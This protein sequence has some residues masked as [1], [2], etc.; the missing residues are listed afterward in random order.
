MGHLIE[1]FGREFDR[2]YQDWR[3]I[4]QQLDPETIYRP[5]ASSGGS[6]GEQVVRSARVVEQTFGGITAN[7]WD[8]PFEWTLPETLTTAEKLLGYFDEVQATRARGFDLFKSD[9]DLMKEIMTP[10]GKMRLASLLL[11]TLVRA[12]H[13][14]LSACE[15][16][17]QIR[18]GEGINES[19][20]EA[21]VSQ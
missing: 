3:E 5:T 10:S 2:M 7:L 4:V 14:Q 11:D 6:C 15:I 18:S 13:Y 17:R 20:L 8:D 12:G 1:W 16:L 9:E 21:G 19:S